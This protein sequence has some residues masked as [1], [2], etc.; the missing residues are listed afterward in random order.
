MH[1]NL[2]MLTIS[3]FLPSFLG[4]PLSLRCHTWDQTNQ[5]LGAGS[6]HSGTTEQAVWQLSNL[7]GACSS[8]T[9]QQVCTLKIYLA[10]NI[11]FQFNVWI[12]YTFTWLRYPKMPK[13]KRE[14]P[15]PFHHFLIPFH[16]WSLFLVFFKS[17]Q[18]LYVQ[19]SKS[20]SRFFFYSFS[21][22]PQH[23]GS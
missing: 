8:L 19:I 18:L 14:V 2:G 1:R 21:C 17:S 5:P 4:C 13:V 11:I 22:A 6:W 3:N 16:N 10:S 15:F 20:E 23:V 7:L 9:R 12:I